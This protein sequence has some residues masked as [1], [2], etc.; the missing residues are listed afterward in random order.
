MLR[1]KV[2]LTMSNGQSFNKEGILSDDDLKIL[3]LSR[4][5]SDIDYKYEPE[6]LR[7]RQSLVHRDLKRVMREALISTYRK[8]RA[9]YLKML[10][11]L[12]DKQRKFSAKA[13]G[14]K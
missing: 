5:L 11:D 12:R 8:K 3:W 10:T 1:K 6:F 7:L 4:T 14:L 9:P 13:I 2:N